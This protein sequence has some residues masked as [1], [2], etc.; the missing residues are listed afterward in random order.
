MRHVVRFL[1]KSHRARLRVLVYTM[2]ICVQVNN[3]ILAHVIIKEC[4]GSY[5]GRIAKYCVRHFYI[6][7]TLYYQRQYISN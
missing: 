1:M 3:I 6:F 7:S 5:Y 2:Y 4:V